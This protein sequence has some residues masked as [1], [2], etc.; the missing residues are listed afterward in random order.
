[1]IS[2]EAKRRASILTFWKKHGLEATEE[3]Y[4]VKERTLYL[5][6]RN[7]KRGGGKLESLNP[8]SRT[9]KHCEKRIFSVE[10]VD[11]VITLRLLHRGMGKDMMTPLLKKQGFNYCPSYIGYCIAYCKK[12]GLIREKPLKK[13][14]RPT[15][16]KL[17]RAKKTGFEI[18]TVV[19]FVDGIKTYILTAINVEH[20]ISFAYGYRSHSSKAAAHFLV[21]LQQ[22]SP[23]PVTEVQTDNGSEFELLFRDACTELGIIQYHTYPRSPKMNAFVERFNRTLHYECIALH[24]GL[25]RDNLTLFNQELITYLLWYNTERPHSSLGYLSPLEYYMKTLSARNCNMCW[26]GT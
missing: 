22:V 19:R 8:G 26:A 2:E 1:M 10:L 6:Q 21:L 15:R 11:A 25:M 18:D 13:P 14:R 12:R 24:R 3:A 16:K 7:L 17:R 9:P 5:W 20:R 4:K 23:I